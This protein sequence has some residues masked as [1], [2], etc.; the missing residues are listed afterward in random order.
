MIPVISD[1]VVTATADVVTADANGLLG[2]LKLN[3]QIESLLNGK[4][5]SALQDKLKATLP[6][7]YLRAGVQI[8]ELQF[9]DLNGKLAAR[10]KATGKLHSGT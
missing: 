7:E 9:F 6:A 10:L 1:G 8:S 5:N 3:G 2:K 4:L